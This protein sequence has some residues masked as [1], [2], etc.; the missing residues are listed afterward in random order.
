MNPTFLLLIFLIGFFNGLRSLTPAAAT[1]W[2]ARLGWLK[3]G[4]GLMWLGTTAGAVIFTLL[5]AA[6]IV[7]DKLPKTPPRTAPVGLIAR[8]V[9]GGFVGACAGT[10]SGQGI[11]VGAIVAIIGALAGTFGGYHARAGLVKALGTPDY[12]VAVIEDLLA[13]GGSVWVVSR[14]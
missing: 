9:M 13:I 12:V 6:E 2:A 8:I 11:T 10:A 5:A 4:A 1:A 7:N 3:L 14:L